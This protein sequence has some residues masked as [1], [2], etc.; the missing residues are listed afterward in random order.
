MERICDAYRG[1]TGTADVEQGQRTVA[2]VINQSS[3]QWSNGQ[4]REANGTEI[5]DWVAVLTKTYLLGHHP[6]V[7]AETVGEVCKGCSEK[8]RDEDLH[9]QSARWYLAGI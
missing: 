2:A 7:H 4:H 8:D 3:V 5:E 1:Q 9:L 6:A